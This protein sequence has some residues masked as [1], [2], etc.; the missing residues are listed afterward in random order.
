M[1]ELH[2]RVYWDNEGEK[3]QLVLI[4]MSEREVEALNNVSDEPHLWFK[5]S[6][7][8]IIGFPSKQVTG[9]MLP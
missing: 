1:G 5:D 9:I 6:T 8:R 4:V 7:G 3:H 2:V